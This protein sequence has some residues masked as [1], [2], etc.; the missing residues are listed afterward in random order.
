MSA[1]LLTVLA[2]L[3][4]TQNVQ[5]P[6][7][8]VRDTQFRLDGEST[9][10]LG[11]SYYGALG[12]AE[13]KPIEQDL[14][15]LRAHGFNWIRVWVTWDDFDNNVCAV[16]PDG[17]VRRPYIGRLKRLCRLAGERRMVVDVT[18]TRGK[19]PNFPANREE[20]LAVMKTLAQELLQFRNVYF[21]VG[22]ERNVGDARY[23]S[24]EDVAELIRAIKAI[25]PDRVC[26]ASDG[27]DISREDVLA[28]VDAGVDCI[29]PHRARNADSPHQT[30]ERTRE[31]LEMMK[32]AKRAVPVHYQEPFRRGYDHYAPTADDFLTDLQ[33]ARDGGAAGWC[34]HNGCVSAR[35]D[36]SVPD[37]RP[38]RSFDMRPE[39]GRLFD[40]LD[41]VEQKFMA[42]LKDATEEG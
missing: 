29:C 6:I 34:F 41:D 18:V 1:A 11:C 31:Y 14:D 38:R 26:T 12:V 28:L 7:L 3:A 8:T 27:G 5:G 13:A 2:V 22:N 9:F 42:R 23:V 4:A 24:I 10:L 35:G 40:Q 19:S 20:H 37:K 33:Q 15:D 32:A 36:E 39:E 16:A 17:S 25:D 21:D 30:A